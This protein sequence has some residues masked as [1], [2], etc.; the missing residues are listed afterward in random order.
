MQNTK[1]KYIDI[2]KDKVY[3][4]FIINSMIYFYKL[5]NYHT[6]VIECEQWITML[7]RNTID[8]EYTKSALIALKNIMIDAANY[9]CVVEDKFDDSELAIKLSNKITSLFKQ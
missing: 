9:F 4:A 6:Q 8:T 3:L 5:R 7:N 2:E 1:L